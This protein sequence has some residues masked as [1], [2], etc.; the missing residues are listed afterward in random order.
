M[1]VAAGGLPSPGLLAWTLL[2]GALGA[3]GANAINCWIDRDIDAVMIRTAHRAIPGGVLSPGE[4]LAFGLALGAA[5]FVVLAIFVNL[6]AAA[7]TLGALVFYVVVYTGWL[8]RSSEQNIVIGGAA[9]A[10]PP[11][12]GWAAVTGEISLLAIYLFAIVFYWTPPHF[13]AL[14]L[15]I[16]DDYRRARVPMLP[17]VKGERETRQQILLYTI[18]LV[19][20]T[21]VVY[22]A[23]LLGII[24]LLGAAVLGA[25]FVW[26]AIRLLTTA[27]REAARGLFKYSVLY[28]S[29]LF[30]VMVLDR[31]VRL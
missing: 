23:G 25:L 28:L 18:A 24:Y 4:G 6:L 31:V 13:W 7:L 27:T 30:G 10:V 9:G 1:A 8:K 11:L 12:V 2:G 19:A 22:A 5:S 15:L 20:I 29:L 17:V 26:C 21:I 16:Q 3:A 14:A